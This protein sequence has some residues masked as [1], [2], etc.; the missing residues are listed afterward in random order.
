[1]LNKACSPCVADCLV[2][3]WEAETGVEE[4]ILTGWPILVQGFK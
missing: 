3:G 4:A 2:T 1:M